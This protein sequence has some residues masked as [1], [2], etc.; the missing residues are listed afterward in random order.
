MNWVLASQGFQKENLKW[1]DGR[2]IF[3]GVHTN[4]ASWTELVVDLKAFA[5][6]SQI[7]YHWSKIIYHSLLSLICY[8][9][10]IMIPCKLFII[11]WQSLIDYLLIIWFK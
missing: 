10:L 9:R 3:N 7:V 11:D 8:L 5:R 2:Y 6:I 4:S 1:T